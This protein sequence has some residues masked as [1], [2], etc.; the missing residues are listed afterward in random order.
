M[1]EILVKLKA[2]G[3]LYEAD[4]E[5]LYCVGCEKFIL[6]SELIDGKCPYHNRLPDKVKEKIG[7]SACKIFYR[8]LRRK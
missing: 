1:A 7:F 5:G 3:V 2:A 4:Y 8:R 6:E